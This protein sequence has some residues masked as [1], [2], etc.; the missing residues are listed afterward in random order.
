[1]GG[2]KNDSRVPFDLRVPFL[3][4]LS[5]GRVVCQLNQR[6][7]ISGDDQADGRIQ[8]SRETHL[9]RCLPN[10]ELVVASAV[11]DRSDFQE[12]IRG[13]VSIVDAR[14]FFCFRLSLSLSP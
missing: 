3:N 6:E 8:D 2:S 5:L 14:P 7:A 9:T 13:R 11:V 1:M 10:S 12:Q 4:G